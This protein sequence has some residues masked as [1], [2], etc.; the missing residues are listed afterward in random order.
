MLFYP[1]KKKCI[2][3]GICIQGVIPGKKK[4]L[5][6]RL[7]EAFSTYAATTNVIDRY[8]V[9][10]EESLKQVIQKIITENIRGIPFKIPV[11]QD[12]IPV[13]AA[14]V[15]EALSPHLRRLG[16]EASRSVDFAEIIENEFQN[17][18]I[19]DLEEIFYRIAGKELRFVE[20]IGFV[21]GFI[22]GVI[23]GVVAVLISV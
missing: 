19:E 1:V 3:P 13:L 22:V 20:V 2:I 17:L 6:K 9:K 21:L 18:D 14:S 16:Q 11:I 8:W 10:I 5:A 4:E 15:G 7:G 23:E 12:A